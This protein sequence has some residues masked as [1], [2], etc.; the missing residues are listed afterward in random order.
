M[1]E[2]NPIEEVGRCGKKLKIRASVVSVPDIPTTT[3]FSRI[4]DVELP[5]ILNAFLLPYFSGM[6]IYSLFIIRRARDDG[7][8]RAGG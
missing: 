4:D 2:F 3:R 1:D 5:I 7:I 6:P 8:N